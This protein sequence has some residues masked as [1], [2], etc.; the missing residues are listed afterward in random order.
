[1]SLE[2]TCADSQISYH[3]F[4]SFLQGKNLFSCSCF[5]CH[6]H[7]LFCR[8][9]WVFLYLVY[10]TPPLGTLT[11]GSQKPGPVLRIKWALASTDISLPVYFGFVEVSLS[12]NSFS[13]PKKV[14]LPSPPSLNMWL[15]LKT[16]DPVKQL[17]S[18]LL[19]TDTLNA[20]RWEASRIKI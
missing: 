3:F 13:K 6:S 7:M 9:L 18:S 20:R 15:W 17:A 19:A 1:M 2:T 8:K 11:Y 16:G 5:K 12:F 14:W 4:F 10:Y